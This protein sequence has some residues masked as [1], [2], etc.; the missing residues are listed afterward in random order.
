MQV[1]GVALLVLFF[2]GGIVGK[3]AY[4]Q[5]VTDWDPK[6]P[7][8]FIM[9]AVWVVG[10]DTVAGTMAFAGMASDIRQLRERLAPRG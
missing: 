5:A 1:F 6:W 3:L 9:A 4:Q 7:G 8:W 2:L 10:I